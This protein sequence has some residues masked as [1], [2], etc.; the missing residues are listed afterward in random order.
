MKKA[1]YQKHQDNTQE[2]S[3]L[4]QGKNFERRDLPSSTVETDYFPLYEIRYSQDY[5]ITHE[6]NNLPVEDYLLIQGRSRHLTKRD[7]EIIQ[8]EVDRNW[9]ELRGKE[10]RDLTAKDP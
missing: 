7:L 9:K 2:G 10:N 5:K 4:S 1:Y 6:S 3:R 8:E